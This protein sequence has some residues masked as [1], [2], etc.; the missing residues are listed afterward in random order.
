MQAVFIQQ[1]AF[2]PSTLLLMKRNPILVRGLQCKRVWLQFAEF[3]LQ[4]LT[5]KSPPFWASQGLPAASTVTF[6]TFRHTLLLLLWLQIHAAGGW[7]SG[8]K[9]RSRVSRKRVTY[10]EGTMPFRD[11]GRLRECKTRTGVVGWP[12]LWLQ[13]QMQIQIQIQIKITGV[14]GWPWL[15][16]MLEA[17]Y[18]MLCLMLCKSWPVGQANF[19]AWLQLWT[20]YH[21]FILH[22]SHS[23]EKQNISPV[24][25]YR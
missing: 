14:A 2:Y 6:C 25:Q 15:W 21:P 8:T 17:Q 22:T 18:S 11:L 7:H 23:L 24:Q 20:S 3:N 12:W 19:T 5:S 9:T 16:L 4:I 10:K 13:I 1:L